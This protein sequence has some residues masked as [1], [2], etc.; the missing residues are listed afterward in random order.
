MPRLVFAAP[1]RSADDMLVRKDP[2]EGGAISSL[3]L[4]SENCRNAR[5]QGIPRCRIS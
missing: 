2:L 5:T 4:L 3:L 1:T